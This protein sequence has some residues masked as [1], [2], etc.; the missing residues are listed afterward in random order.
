MN[1]KKNFPRHL[2]FN[3]EHPDIFLQLQI[4]ITVSVVYTRVIA[5]VKTVCDCEHV[6]LITL[7]ML[8]S[9]FILTCD[10]LGSHHTD[11]VMH[12]LFTCTYNVL[13][14]T[15]EYAMLVF[16]EMGCSIAYTSSY[17]LVCALD[18]FSSTP[19][20]TTVLAGCDD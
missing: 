16:T 9:K 7:K 1:R 13:C 20:S 6:L 18:L 12:E 14:L 15:A 19:S 11:R 4:Y 10:S 3:S 5:I 2:P 8:N 17:I